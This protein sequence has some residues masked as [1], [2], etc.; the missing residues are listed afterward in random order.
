MTTAA[1]WRALLDLTRSKVA[2]HDGQRGIVV[3]KEIEDA[4]QLCVAMRH[5]SMSTRRAQ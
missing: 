3:A 1:S 4:C 2:T 5:Q